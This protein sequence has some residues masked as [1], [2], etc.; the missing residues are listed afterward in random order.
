MSAPRLHCFKMKCPQISSGNK[1]VFLQMGGVGGWGGNLLS[2]GGLKRECFQVLTGLVPAF[3]PRR[4]Q[5]ALPQPGC[6]MSCEQPLCW[7]S[8]A[9]AQPSRTGTWSTLCYRGAQVKQKPLAL[10]VQPPRLKVHV[11]PTFIAFMLCSAT[12]AMN[13]HN[14]VE[15]CECGASDRSSN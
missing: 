1:S 12:C 2:H 7:S 6:R 4:S 9:G 14:C 5:F 13:S 3:P 8:R 10:T 11:V 15:L